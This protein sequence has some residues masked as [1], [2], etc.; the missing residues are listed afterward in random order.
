MRFHRTLA[1]FNRPYRVGAPW[2]SPGHQD[3]DGRQEVKLY[4][5][6]GLYDLIDIWGGHFYA[7]GPD[8]GGFDAPDREWYSD[9]VLKVRAMLDGS[10]RADLPIW[11]GE[12]NRKMV[13]V[14]DVLAEYDRYC[15]RI[16]GAVE[17]VTWFIWS[18]GDPAF[19]DMQWS[20]IAD[21]A[22]AMQAIIDKYAAYSPSPGPT[23]PP[24]PVPPFPPA[25]A[26]GGDI[27]RKYNLIV[28]ETADI[29]ATFQD[30]TSGQVE[31]HVDGPTDLL[32]TLNTDDG[33][34]PAPNQG[35]GHASIIM[36]GSSAYFPQNGAH[37][38]WV[39]T[40]QGAKVAGL[41]MMPSHHHPRTIFY[42]KQQP[43]PGPT[44]PPT[45]D[46]G[47]FGAFADVF[48]AD[49]SI[50]LA[51][52]QIMYLPETF[53]CAAQDGHQ[54]IMVWDGKTAHKIRKTT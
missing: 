3:I 47:W 39:T 28:T 33:R 42:R 16:A 21:R 22:P 18:S 8:R 27:A 44:P 31:L 14:G 23:P 9:R 26:P 11:I 30:D 6:A 40:C 7:E 4:A 19:G 36:A 13:D 35:P 2:D 54:T 37:G 5:Q 45:T 50:G 49:P 12:C 51:K 43:A 1:G 41:G 48:R 38:P 20:K 10:D 53:D 15:G 25:P 24:G 46:G 52:G 32:V 29:G 34:N 17:A